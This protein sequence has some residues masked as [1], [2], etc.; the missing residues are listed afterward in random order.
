MAE[1]FRVLNTGPS[2]VAA[3]LA[4]AFGTAGID[5][6]RAENFYGLSVAEE[7]PQSAGSKRGGISGQNA[8]DQVFDAAETQARSRLEKTRDPELMRRAA[9]KSPAEAAVEAQRN[10]FRERAERSMFGEAPSISNQ[11]G[12]SIS[13]RSEASVQEDRIRST[14]ENWVEALPDG[15]VRIHTRLGK[16]GPEAAIVT[17]PVVIRPRAPNPVVRYTESGIPVSARRDRIVKKSQEIANRYFAERQRKIDAGEME[18]PPKLKTQAEIWEEQNAEVLARRKKHGRETSKN[19]VI[20]GTTPEQSKLYYRDS[21]YVT[22]VDGKAVP[23][24]DAPQEQLPKGWLSKDEYEKAKRRPDVKSEVEVTYQTVKDLERTERPD[25]GI[26]SEP[27][28]ETIVNTLADMHGGN[29]DDG[30]ALIRGFFPDAADAGA[31]KKGAAGAGSGLD[32][33]DA[34]PDSHRTDPIRR[35]SELKSSMLDGFVSFVSVVSF[36]FGVN[37]AHALEISETSETEPLFDPSA[38][39]KAVSAFEDLAKEIERDYRKVRAKVNA[40]HDERKKGAEEDAEAQSCGQCSLDG[41]QAAKW[42]EDFALETKKSQRASKDFYGLDDPEADTG[43]EHQTSEEIALF[44]TALS[45]PEEMR[46]L[47]EGEG[48]ASTRKARKELDEIVSLVGDPEHPGSILSVLREG[49]VE[50]PVVLDYVP[51]AAERLGILTPEEEEALADPLGTMTYVFISFSLG[52]EELKELFARNA[53]K[54][55][56]V[57]VLRGIPDG[58]TFGEGVKHIQG[59][60]AQF[61]PMP[62]VVVDPT[63]FRDFQIKAVPTVIRVRE[64]KSVVQVRKSGMKRTDTAELLGKATGLHSDAWIKSQLE[65]GRTGDFGQQGEVRE[66]WERDLIEVAKERVMRIDWEEKKE[67]AAK[68]AWANLQYENLPTASKSVVRMIDPTILVEEDILDLNGNAIRRAGDRVNPMD[69]R[70][71]TLALIV[72]NPL[73]ESE[74]KVVEAELPKL[75]KEHPEVMLLATDMVKDETGWDAYTR[76]TD[77]LDSH[78]YLLTPE[79]RERFLLR[80]T[81]SVV[82]GDNERKLFVVR[83]IAPEVS[84]SAEQEREES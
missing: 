7:S 66:I 35:Q 36:A 41:A 23:V 22:F 69:I 44:N 62:N 26:R 73:V 81:P 20:A 64:K 39:N 11:S 13:D 57:L 14:S 47:E 50:N 18:P 27:S 43:I 12:R 78:V 34:F 15:R 4:L 30:S 24:V 33:R 46:T 38:Q 25:A 56:T 5:S 75:K 37:T 67:R 51:D 72:F 65:A 77:R 17:D 61:D 83:E 3:A 71:L 79:V 10:T 53:G 74:L 68:R 19:F 2:L 28:P 32:I 60:A 29:S 8:L 59:L 9:G 49:L 76:L 54:D 40:V 84:S 16:F 6:A 70:P 82:T 55:D 45:I 1:K 21:T 63:L 48:D 42:A 31:E 52:D 58:M 80:A